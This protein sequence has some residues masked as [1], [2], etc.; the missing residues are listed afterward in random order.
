VLK[1]QRTL[2]E[3][4]DKVTAKSK[5]SA[6]DRSGSKKISNRLARRKIGYLLPIAEKKARMFFEEASQKKT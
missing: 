6:I 4:R 3:Q 2:T 5:R 1:K